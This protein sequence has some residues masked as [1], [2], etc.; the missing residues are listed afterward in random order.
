[1]NNPEEIN[2][3]T[4][5]HGYIFIIKDGDNEIMAH[6]SALSGM[7][8]IYYNDDII[9]KKRSLRI[10]S[11][12]TFKIKDHNYTVIFKVTNIWRGRVTCTV[13]KDGELIGSEEKS[14][15]KGSNLKIFGIL[16]LLLALGVIVGYS[17]GYLI[18]ALLK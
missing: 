11:P 12:H 17:F 8:E 7:E 6:C 10:T 18:E 13:E 14:F 15:Y 16:F 2:T 1:M 5:K 3:V 9:S 4:F